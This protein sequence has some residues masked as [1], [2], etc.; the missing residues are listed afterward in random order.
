MAKKLLVKVCG[1]RE[2]ENIHQL[3][4]LAIDYIGHI[5]YPKSARYIADA[6]L[7]NSNPDIKKT[8]VFVNASLEE[9]T[10]AIKSYQLHSIQLHGDESV[11]LIQQL[12]QSGVEIIKAF[13]VNND[14]DWNSLEPYL[15]HIDYLLF[16]SK[17]S[18]YGG[19]GERFNWEKL[20]EY[21]YDKPYFLSGGLSLENIQEAVEFEDSR[22]IGL[23]LNSRFE[24]SPGLKD[25]EKIKAAL[26]IINHE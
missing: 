9:I 22:L 18:Q 1:M 2:D 26:K 10:Q 5:F 8:G 11:E 6:K 12:N 25:I 16:D 23:D 20:I 15:N 13:G 19:T 24:I 3:T 4:Q 7:L 17:S 14:F 21:P